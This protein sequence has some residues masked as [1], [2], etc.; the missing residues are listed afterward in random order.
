MQRIKTSLELE[1][2]IKLHETGWII[3]RAGW[4][5]ILLLVIASALGLF[6]NGLL[7]KAE[8]TDN[9]NKLSFEKRARYE[10]PMQMTIH[11]TSRNNRIEVR[12]PQSYFDTVALDKVVPEPQEQTI[13]KG[14]AIFTFETEGPSVIKFYLIPEKTGTV[15]AQIQVNESDFSISQFIYP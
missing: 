1:D 9:T 15:K 4:I 14:F 10:A 5:I 8:I 13:A 6:G 12:I 3:Q 7:S 11:A 2:D